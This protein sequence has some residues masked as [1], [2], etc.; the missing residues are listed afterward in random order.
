M[1]P[2]TSILHSP[3]YVS[4]VVPWGNRTLGQAVD[5]VHVHGFPLSDAVP[6]NTCAIGR[7]V[8][9][10]GDV[11]SLLK[12]SAC[13]PIPRHEC[14]KHMASGKRILTSPQHA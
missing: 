3:P 2:R 5:T 12:L 6:V 7:K 13:V 1:V 14:K 10:D 11:D 9:V 8:V 4:E